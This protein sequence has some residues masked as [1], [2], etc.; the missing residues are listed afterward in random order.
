MQ[1]FRK[2]YEQYYI[3]RVT[4]LYTFLSLQGN[5]LYPTLA[6]TTE[7]NAFI[8]RYFCDERKLSCLYSIINQQR[9]GHL[10]STVDAV[11]EEYLYTFTHVVA[12]KIY[13][14]SADNAVELDSQPEI[15]IYF[16][17]FAAGES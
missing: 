17:G 15:E 10:L 16:F 6:L 3:P 4:S 14:Y 2:G 1:L 9:I 11:K 8:H 7:N 12:G 5:K 13:Y